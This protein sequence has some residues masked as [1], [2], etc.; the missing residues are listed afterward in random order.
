LVRPVLIFD[1]DGV[2]A[3]TEPLHWRSW[4]ELL[5]PYCVD[6]GWD[7]YRKHCQGVADYRMA[8]VLA[9]LRPEIKVPN[10]A[11]MLE[12]RKKMVLRSALSKPPISSATVQMLG[13]LRKQAWRLGVVT[14]AAM[15][16]AGPIL[17][18]AAVHELFEVLVFGN[19]VD[20]HKPDPQPYLLA[21]ERFRVSTG[22]AFEDSDSGMKSASEAGFRAVRVGDARKLASI[23]AAEIHAV[24]ADEAQTAGSLSLRNQHASLPPE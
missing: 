21:A 17:R 23:V 16:E 18:K 14:S 12:R 6:L 10:L 24:V 7:E 9:Q 2:L 4:R 5:R 1:F 15:S 3:D 8:Q 11:E 19:E 22:I 20:R 13:Q